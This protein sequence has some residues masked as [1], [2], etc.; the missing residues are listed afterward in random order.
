MFLE[1]DHIVTRQ[2]KDNC[3]DKYFLQKL[4]DM[5]K[6]QKKQSPYE[7]LRDE[8]VEYFDSI[9]RCDVTLSLLHVICFL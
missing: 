8:I 6:K 4:Q 2:H 3:F 5:S 7:K 1:F 9:V